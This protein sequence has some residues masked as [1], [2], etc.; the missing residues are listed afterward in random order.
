M[1]IVANKMILDTLN[2]KLKDTLTVSNM[3]IVLSTVRDVIANYEITAYEIEETGKDMM[4]EAFL[5]AM[6]VEGKSDKTVTRY[7]YILG[8]FFKY[9]KVPSHHVTQYHIRTYLAKEKERGIADNT[10]RGYCWVFSA[11]FGWLHRDGIIQRNPMGNIGK[12]KVQ[13]KVKEVFTEVEI[14]KLKN[15]CTLTRDKAI[16][17]FLK[18]TGCRISEVTSLDRDDIDFTNLECIVLGKGNKQR[19][20]YLDAVT[21]MVLQ[22]YLNERKDDSPALFVGK[23][24]ERL[25]PGGVRIMLNRIGKQAGVDHVHPH[26]FRR[27][28]ITELVNRGMPIEQVKAIAGHEKIDTTMAYVVID[29]QNVKNSYRKYA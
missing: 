29:Q 6:N 8:N 25:R 12:V 4:L 18:S 21:G 15:A 14:E 17:S 10:I 20:V 23:A 19:A 2:E 26:K 1:S 13:K 5:D 16:I 9:V 7:R 24:G 22:K 11:Y 3:E 28:E 27:T